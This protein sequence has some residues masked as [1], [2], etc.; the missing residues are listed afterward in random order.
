MLIFYCRI[1]INKC[2]VLRAV[3]VNEG[4]KKQR[5]ECIKEGI[6]NQRLQKGKRRKVTLKGTDGIRNR[7]RTKKYYF[8]TAFKIKQR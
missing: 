5:N 8:K 2:K 6:L 4:E 1:K 7:N 3:W